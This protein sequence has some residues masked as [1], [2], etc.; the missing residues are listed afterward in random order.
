MTFVARLDGT[1]AQ[2]HKVGAGDTVGESPNRLVR[3]LPLE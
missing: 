2:Q 1:P 3:I